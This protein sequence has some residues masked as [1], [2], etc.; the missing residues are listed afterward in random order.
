MARARS[1]SSNGNGS[2]RIC[3]GVKPLLPPLS[4]SHRLRGGGG[5][6]ERPPSV[7]R[8]PNI[9]KSSLLA[10]STFHVRPSM[11]KPSDCESEEGL[12]NLLF[13]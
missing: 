13:Y 5:D 1:S 3:A 6:G 12:Q 9:L 8:Q 4:L 7:Q 10:Q 11:R 2:G